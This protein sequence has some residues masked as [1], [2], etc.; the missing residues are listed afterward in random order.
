MSAQR[1][2]G[3]YAP[4]RHFP[5]PPRRAPQHFFMIFGF[6]GELESATIPF[7]GAR[8]GITRWSLLLRARTT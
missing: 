8:R 1:Y 5:A 3:T 2:H 6:S 7:P 4:G